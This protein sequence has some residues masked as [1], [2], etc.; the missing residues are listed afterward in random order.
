[1]ALSEKQEAVRKKVEAELS[2]YYWFNKVC[3]DDFPTD[4]EID[5]NFQEAVDTVGI[6]TAYWDAPSIFDLND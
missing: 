3:L 4:E 1:M 5:E 6:Q 2:Q